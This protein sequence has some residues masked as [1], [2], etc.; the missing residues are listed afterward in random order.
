MIQPV[1]MSETSIDAHDL[2]VAVQN[3]GDVRDP[4]A[5]YARRRREKPVAHEQHM[6]AHVT[7]VYRFDD[8]DRMLKDAQTY[9]SAIN[10]RWMEEFLGKTIIAMDGQE[11]FR[12]RSLIG[13]AF[14]QKA[15]K[16]WEDVLIRPT[17]NELIDRFASRGTAELVR[18]FAW[19]F[20]V[21]VFAKIEGVAE[22]DYDRWGRWAIAL[23]RLVLDRETGARAAVEVRD[24][25]QPMIEQR[26]KSP[27]GDLISDLVT[28]EL[29]GHRLPDD[30][31]HGF[32]RLLVPAGAGTTYRITGTLM[33]AL[34]THREQL[35]AVQADRSLIPA[36]VEEALRWEAPVQYASREATVDAELGGV[37]IPKGSAVVAVLGSANRDESRW[38]DPDRFDIFREPK[39]TLPFSN[40][41]HYCIGAHLAKLETIVALNALLD[42]LPDIRLADDDSD[43]HIVGWAFRSPT[44]LPVKFRPA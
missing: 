37:E 35:D 30:I 26:R 36:A 24:Y 41:P 34:L 7:R 16:A 32:L 5:G 29:D 17:A 31:I 20:P 6:G 22:A 25:F 28:A 19:L 10:G 39:L 3:Y 18:D 38:T 9:S 8:C 1:T 11:H 33:L 42:R 13:H 44:H 21:R 43:P 2:D 15:V 27:V 23:E 14:R 40:G 12:T 4:Y